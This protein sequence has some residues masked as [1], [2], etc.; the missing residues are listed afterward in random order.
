MPASTSRF[1]VYLCLSVA[2]IVTL[3]VASTAAAQE[4][5]PIGGFAAD[6]RGVFSKHKLEPDVAQDLNV[7]PGNLPTRSYGLSGGAHVFPLRIGKVT[8]GF[9][10]EIIM[11]RGSQTLT[12]DT[13]T[14]STA[15]TTTATPTRDF[16]TVQR[17]FLTFAP[18]V[19]FNFGHRNGWSYISGGLFGASKLYLDRADKPGTD[20]P[21][22]Q[23]LNYGAGARWFTNHHMA[24]S[25]DIR[26]FTLAEQ[27]PTATVV[28]Q[29]HT[30]LMVLRAGIAVR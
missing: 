4:D 19:S 5:E 1:R 15:T 23:T 11:S 3:A 9:G 28:G 18:E 29:P 8:F 6:I 20:A 27:P 13:T 30:T 17:H 21:F 7:V 25:V 22:R 10:G 12:P 16:A 26:W 24:F 14:S 2:L